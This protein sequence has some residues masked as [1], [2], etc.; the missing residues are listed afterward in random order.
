[1]AEPS[2]VLGKIGEYWGLLCYLPPLGTIPPYPD[3]W[4]D[5]KSSTP[6]ATT[7]DSNA[8]M[9]QIMGP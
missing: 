8:S 3:P 7:L 5:P 9:V 6:S 1:M 2:G 4:D